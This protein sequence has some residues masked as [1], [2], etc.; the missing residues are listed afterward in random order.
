MDFIFTPVLAE[1]LRAKVSAF[2]HLFLQSE[3]LQRSLAS[4]TALNIEMLAR[5]AAAAELRDDDTGQHT[6]RVGNLSV[7]IAERLGVPAL[8]VG[9]IRLAA[10]LHDV[11]KI[12]LPDAILC[13]PGKLTDAE[14]E[15]MKTH[16][17]VGAADAGR[18][19]VR[20]ARGGRA[21]RADPPR[22]MGRQRLSQRPGRR[23][24]PDRRAHRG[25]GRRLRRAH[26][27]AAVQAGVEQAD[28]L[29]EITSHAGE[30]F[31]P[32]SWTPSSPVLAGGSLASLIAV[33]FDTAIYQW[34]A[35]ERR[36][37]EAA[38]HERP[39]LERVTARIHAELRR[40]LGGA[41]TVDELAE[42]YDRGTGWCLDLAYAVAPGAPWAWDARTVADAAFARY[43]REAVD[44]AGGRRLE[45]RP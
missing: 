41:F 15:Q 30:H 7:A 19:R 34:R 27:R 43:V 39:A 24:H 44:F 21:G 14:F 37:A 6:R 18:Q 32:R 16:A 36:L 8:D 5:L 35:G 28:A 33:S 38:P 10:P 25:G 29:A 13:K 4:I 23:G 22:E 26:A 45:P 40:R 17:T 42:L 1:V 11:G 12:A 3:E 20:A 9:L 31:D 2:V